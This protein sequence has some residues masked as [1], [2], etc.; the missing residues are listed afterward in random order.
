MYSNTCLKRPLKK[1]TTHILKTDNSLLQVESIAESIL[2]Y[3]RSE[4]SSN[5]S[6]KPCFDLL[7]SGCLRQVWLYIAS[8]QIGAFLVILV[9][10]KEDVS[11]M[12]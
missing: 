10:L 2:Q 9:C 8:L 11:L 12:Y 5:R 7:L 1:E 6:L 4:L 3:F